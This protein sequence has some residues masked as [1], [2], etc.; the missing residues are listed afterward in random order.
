MNLKKILILF[1]IFT[2]LV[3]LTLLGNSYLQFFIIGIGT[4][5]LT[6][7]SLKYGDWNVF[8]YHSTLVKRIFFFIITL[9]ISAIF[10]TSV[11][12]TLIKINTY[13]FAIM[14][15]IATLVL[16]KRNNLNIITTGLIFLAFDLTVISII[17]Q[18]NPK[19][20]TLLPGMNI[21]YSTY[22]HNHLASLLLLVIPI[23]WWLA[24]NPDKKTSEII[25]QKILKYLAVLFS[26]AL[27]LSFGRTAVF[28]GLI[29]VVALR[30][31][32]AKKN[33]KISKIHKIIEIL[34]Y[35]VLFLKLLFSS[36]SLV[37]P[38]FYCP[39]NY[40]DNKICKPINTE[41]RPYYW[42][43]A[44]YILKDHLLFGSGPGTFQIANERYK[45]SP[46]LTTNSAHNFVLDSLS[47]LG[48]I[49]G[50]SLIY[51]IYQPFIA[52]TNNGKYHQELKNIFSKNKST[53]TNIN[54]L[55]FCIWLSLFSSYLN[56]LFDFDWNFVGIF[57]IS[58]ILLA[59][60]VK[61]I[62]LEQRLVKKNITKF[63]FI[64]LTIIPITLMLL[65]FITDTKIVAGD[66]EKAFR[67]FPYFYWHQE[68]YKNEL[69]EELY[70]KLESIYQNHSTIYSFL[71]SK[72]LHT[73]EEEKLAE[74]RN[75]LYE[76]DPWQKINSDNFEYY[77]KTNQLDLAEKDLELSLKMLDK[78]LS[79]KNQWIFNNNRIK[80]LADNCVI[81]ADK[82]FIEKPIKSVMLYKKAREINPWIWGT[83]QSSILSVNDTELINN[84]ISFFREFS[85]QEIDM[86]QTNK[87]NFL[88]KYLDT[89][90][91]LITKNK[92]ENIDLEQLKIDLTTI[93]TAN[94]I[95][96][97][98]VAHDFS[99]IFANEI[100]R[101][102]NE[103]KLIESIYLAN[104]WIDTEEIYSSYP[105]FTEFDRQER[106]AITKIFQ[107]QAEEL[108]LKEDI[109]PEEEKLAIELTILMVKIIPD[110]YLVALQPGNIY[111]FLNKPELAKQAFE[112]C[113]NTYPYQHP[114]QEC[115]QTIENIEK[116]QFYQYGYFDVANLIYSEK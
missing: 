32:F 91:K 73:N 113:V 66:T 85:V 98:E 107:K 105:D 52:I 104:F 6:F 97:T 75:K 7:S 21:L 115:F 33:I 53:K 95:L 108:L 41:P 116:K 15:F 84:Q 114:H 106:F 61:E 18:F 70:P 79:N 11:P 72:K 31:L 102:V 101:L 1:F 57:S 27:L 38:D 9:T 16:Y 40:L 80:E 65:Y 29:E 19:L 20:A 68:I 23:T 2:Y 48:L 26:F 99:K 49:G 46:Q 42:L 63:L 77:L 43:Q 74:L 83:H 103:K 3:F 82:I 81:L 67:F 96:V 94:P 92:I 35:S 36:I 87:G 25:P 64:L 14:V 34:F 5:L 37:K 51:F 58:L 54:G 76:I 22:G 89:I 78:S 17:F 56:A 110:N 100:K 28:L 30:M 93:I 59:I 86:W 47:E 71:I 4:V 45:N 50:I 12:L 55:L 88:Y 69:K 24:N 60:L 13:V 111:L 109:S 90:K 10:T 112:Q 62:N 8:N 39:I 44:I